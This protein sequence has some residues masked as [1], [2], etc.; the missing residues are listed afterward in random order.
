MCC[1]HLI[2]RLLY[3][4]IFSYDE[5][6]T[7][8]YKLPREVDKTKLEVYFGELFSNRGWILLEKESW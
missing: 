3:L 2:G 8:N 4:Q 6:K 7:T 5:L 1:L